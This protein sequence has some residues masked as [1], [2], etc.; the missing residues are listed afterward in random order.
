MS[1]QTVKNKTAGSIQSGGR[2]LGAGGFGCVVTPP[3][4][5]RRS[6]VKNVGGTKYVSKLIVEKLD[7][8]GLRGIEEEMSVYKIGRAHV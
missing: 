7:K 8:V 6:T 1:S 4:P 3:V 5:C 2:K